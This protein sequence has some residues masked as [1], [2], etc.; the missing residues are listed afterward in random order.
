MATK[1]IVAQPAVGADRVPP[2]LLI[3]LPVYFPSSYPTSLPRHVAFSR[4]WTIG[5][6]IDV[7]AEVGRVENRNNVPGAQP[8]RLF[9]LRTRTP[10]AP[11]SQSL[12]NLIPNVIDKTG[13]VIE[14]GD[15][16][17]DDYVAEKDI[18]SACKLC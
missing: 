18:K 1:T 8:L 6:C 4:N 9:P 16:L 14:F 10:V 5:K 12:G 17:D 3:T 15:E 11:P 13:F 7:A 2:E